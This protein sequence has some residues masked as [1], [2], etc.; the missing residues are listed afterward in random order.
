MLIDGSKV[1]TE[2][3]DICDYLDE[4][5]ADYPLYPAEPEAKTQ[6]KELI[7]KIGPVVQVFVECCIL[8]KTKTPEEWLKS[9][10]EAL[11]IF[12]EALEKR[13]MK[14]FGGGKPGMVS[15]TISANF[16]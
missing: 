10:V 5:Y 7:N 15:S 6:D 16:D 4:K 13:G 1:V 8:K 3:L 12:E 14:Y 9:F 2:S 11:Q